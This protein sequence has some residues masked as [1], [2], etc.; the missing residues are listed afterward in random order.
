MKSAKAA[1]DNV[2]SMVAGKKKG[3][4]DNAREAAAA[5]RKAKAQTKAVNARIMSKTR[6]Y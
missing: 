6:G 3:W 4:S 1:N 5:E 2:S